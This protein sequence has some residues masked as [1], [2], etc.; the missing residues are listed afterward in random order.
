M[1]GSRGGGAREL[2]RRL[3]SLLRRLYNS[4]LANPAYPSD[5]ATGETTACSSRSGRAAGDA[6]T[7]T[8]TIMKAATDIV[9]LRFDFIDVMLNAPSEGTCSDA[10]LV[11]SGA[12]AVS[13]KVIPTN[14]CGDLSG[15]HL[16][17]S[18]KDMDNVTLTIT[19][20]ATSTQKWNILVSQFDSTQTDYLAPRGCLQYFRQ[21]IGRITSFNNVNTTGMAEMLNDHMY[22]ICIAQNDD[23]CDVALTAN[24]FDLDGSAGACTDSLTFGTSQQCGTTFGTSD[25]LLWN[26]TGS[27]NVPFMSDSSNTNMREGFDISYVLLPC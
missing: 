16:Y 22:T 23:Y 1:H 19:L 27:Y 24:V 9:Q 2:R 26:Y 15:Q 5:A 14:L 10:T 13:T 20:N 17:A 3:R 12:D 21:D 11:I 7:W 18:V 25:S 8:Y 6:K 4:Y